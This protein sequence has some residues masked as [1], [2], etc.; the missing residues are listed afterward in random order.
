MLVKV[1][2]SECLMFVLLKADIVLIFIFIFKISRVNGLHNLRLLCVNLLHV[3][4]ILPEVTSTSFLYLRGLRSV[5]KF[6]F[7]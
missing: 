2:M 5:I 4:L 7:H 3:V 6:C 1:A